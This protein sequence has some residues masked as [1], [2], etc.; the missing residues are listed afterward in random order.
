[1]SILILK[2]HKINKYKR[3]NIFPGLLTLLL[4]R[5]NITPQFLI[6]IVNSDYLPTVWNERGKKKS[7]FIEEKT[8][9][10]S[11]QAMWPR[12]TSRAMRHTDRIYPWCNVMT[13]SLYVSGLPPK[14]TFLQSYQEKTIKQIPIEAYPTRNSTS[15]AQNF[16]VLQKQGKI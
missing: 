5:Q 9:K 4:R 1:M 8:D 14:N 6:I 15:V 11:P 13:M 7:H 16:E 12:L 3:V 2:S 10:L